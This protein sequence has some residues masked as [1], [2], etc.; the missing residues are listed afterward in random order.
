ML[1]IGDLK[2]KLF[3]NLSMQ[4]PKRPFGEFITHPPLPPSFSTDDDSWGND[5]SKGSLPGAG[6]EEAVKLPSVQLLYVLSSNALVCTSIC[7][8]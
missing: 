3:S 1:Y 2:C 6:E 5:H 8:V 4:R 7:K